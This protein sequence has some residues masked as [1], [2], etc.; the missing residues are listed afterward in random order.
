MKPP[1]ASSDPDSV[2]PKA[3]LLTL[4]DLMAQA[5]EEGRKEFDR[6]VAEGVVNDGNFPEF[7]EN[8]TA[9]LVDKFGLQV[10]DED[11]DIVT[12]NTVYSKLLTYAS[13][14]YPSTEA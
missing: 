3:A 7:L 2:D 4:P 13:V 8:I 6:L 10:G 5:D 14:R 12:W 11:N 9:D 1:G